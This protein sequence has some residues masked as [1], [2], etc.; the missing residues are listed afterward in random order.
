ML[1]VDMTCQHKLLCKLCML[2][3][4][5]QL[6]FLSESHYFSEIDKYDNSAKYVK[7]SYYSKRYKSVRNALCPHQTYQN[8]KVSRSVFCLY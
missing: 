5:H 2:I 1:H 7:L 6:F 4:S 8:N 3:A